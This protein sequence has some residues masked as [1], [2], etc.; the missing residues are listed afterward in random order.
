MSKEEILIPLIRAIEEE[1]DFSEKVKETLIFLVVAHITDPYSLSLKVL[2][3]NV[4]LHLSHIYNVC[5]FLEE[6]KFISRTKKGHNIYFTVHQEELEKFMEE[7]KLRRKIDSDTITRLRQ[8]T[9][10]I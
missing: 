1:D 10:T 3:K 6:R 8:I 2:R 7:R 4:S 5:K 9:K